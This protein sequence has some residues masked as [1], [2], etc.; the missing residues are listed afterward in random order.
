MGFAKALKEQPKRIVMVVPDCRSGSSLTCIMRFMETLFL[1]FTTLMLVSEMTLLNFAS[2][3]L[4]V[5]LGAGDEH[6]R[7]KVWVELKNCLRIPYGG[8]EWS[9]DFRDFA[10]FAWIRK[11]LKSD[12]LHYL[13]EPMRGGGAMD[14]VE[15]RFLN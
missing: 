7:E 3:S 15:H 9:S 1:C 11:S 8:C 10:S 12:C 13:L 14:E 4:N 2:E 5:A 6:R